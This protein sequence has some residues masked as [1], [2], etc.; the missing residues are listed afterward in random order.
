MI[1]WAFSTP[2]T[3]NMVLFVLPQQL[4]S[5]H[6]ISAVLRRYQCKHIVQA[7]SGSNWWHGDKQIVKPQSSKINPGA[8]PQN[9]VSPHRPSF[10]CGCGD[11]ICP[12]SCCCFYCK[13]PFPQDKKYWRTP[14]MIASL[15]CLCTI[16]F[17]QYKKTLLKVFSWLL[18]LQETFSSKQTI[19]VHALIVMIASSGCLCT[20]SFPQNKQTLFNVFSWLLLLQKIFSS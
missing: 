3:Q 17:P 4:Q 18:L 2:Y 10:L 16:S 13:R 8:K 5:L 11:T 19:L 14:C 6:N 9:L 1:C 15:D 7:W 12:S 20:I